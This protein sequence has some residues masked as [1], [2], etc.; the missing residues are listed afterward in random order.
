MD[1]LRFQSGRCL[2]L[3]F[4]AR[5]PLHRRLI[6]SLFPFLRFFFPLSYGLF[7]LNS[8]CIFPQDLTAPVPTDKSRLPKLLNSLMP[9]KEVSTQ[10]LYSDIRTTNRFFLACFFLAR[11]DSRL[12]LLPSTTI[13]LKVSATVRS[14]YSI[15][16]LREVARPKRTLLVLTYPKNSGARG[17]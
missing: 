11:T 10:G 17:Q 1:A 15:F 16:L 12:S 6:G 7:F 5:V 13:D 3:Q 8:K 9:S 14:K 2:K 4:L